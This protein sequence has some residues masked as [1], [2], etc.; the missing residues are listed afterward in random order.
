MTK[1]RN[2]KQ[3]ILETLMEAPELSVGELSRRFGVSEV[4]IRSDRPP[5]G[6]NGVTVPKTSPSIR[7]PTPD[8]T[9]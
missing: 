5:R 6:S 2:R 1:K 9:L 4:T 8:G 7:T 3:L